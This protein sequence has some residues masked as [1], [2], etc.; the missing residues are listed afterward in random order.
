MDKIGFNSINKFIEYLNSIKTNYLAVLM[1]QNEELNKINLFFN[2]LKSNKLIDIINQISP[3]IN[4]YLAAFSNKNNIYSITYDIF[5]KIF[6]EFDIYPNVIGNNIL[7]N[8]FYELYRMK[9]INNEKFEE[10]KKIEFEDIYKAIGIIALYLKNSSKLDDKKILLG[11]FYKIAESKKINLE[12]NFNFN[13]S[14]NLKN[15]IFEISKIYYGLDEIEEPEYKS[16]LEN[17][18]L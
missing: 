12:L 5:L 11:L 10:N 15:K 8:I 16:F 7:K 18:F 1:K 4:I 17:P 13:F 2:E 6:T 14:D 9:N 3:I